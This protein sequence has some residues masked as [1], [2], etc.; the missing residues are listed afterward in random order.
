VDK[1]T[2]EKVHVEGKRKRAAERAPVR[3]HAPVYREPPRG[4]TRGPI[5]RGPRGWIVCTT[6]SGMFSTEENPVR[7]GIRP[8]HAA[9]HLS[10]HRMGRIRRPVDTKEKK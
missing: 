1:K 5:V 4:Q 2:L 6:C 8:R 3:G 9:K 10:D 7:Y